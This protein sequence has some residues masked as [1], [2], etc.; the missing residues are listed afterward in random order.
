MT[1]ELR[2]LSFKTSL[3]ESVLCDMHVKIQLGK[4]VVYLNTVFALIEARV[5]LLFNR[6]Q[7]LATVELEE[8][9][10]LVSF[11]SNF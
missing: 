8:V 6:A 2:Q 10:L 5:P 1:L 11:Y 4:I 7:E 9:Q 3:G